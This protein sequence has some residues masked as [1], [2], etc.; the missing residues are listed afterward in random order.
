MSVWTVYASMGIEIDGEIVDIQEVGE[1]GTFHAAMVACLKFDND[2]PHCDVG[3]WV[4][5]SKDDNRKYYP[6]D[7]Y[8]RCDEDMA[9][10]RHMS[11]GTDDY[12]DSDAQFEENMAAIVAEDKEL[13]IKY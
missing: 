4:E 8:D 2:P 9:D 7:F 13:D 11:Y 6:E 3:F 1:Y 12:V 5:S 10:F